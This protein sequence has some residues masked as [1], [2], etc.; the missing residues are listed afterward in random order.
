MQMKI[1]PRSMFRAQFFAV[2]WLSLVQIATFNFLVGN[3]PE[4]C[5]PEQPQGFTCPGATTFY[6][7]SVIW[8]VVGPKRMFG[9][10]ALFSWINYF[11]LVGAVCTVAHWLIARRYP[12]SIAVS[13]SSIICFTFIC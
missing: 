1:P 11:W 10:G 5:D 2:V 9:P 7:A 6:N 3:I 4:F 12:R 13:S 8:G